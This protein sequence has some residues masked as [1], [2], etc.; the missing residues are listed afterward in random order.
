TGSSSLTDIISLLI[1]ACVE[2]HVAPDLDWRLD[3]LPVD[4]A[5]DAIA[6]L[7]FLPNPDPVRAVHLANPNQRHWRELI[8]WMNLFGYR[9]EIVP[10]E[11][12]LERLVGDVKTHKENPLR[13]LVQ[14]FA[15]RPENE[16]GWYLPQLYEEPRRRK[17][18]FDITRELLKNAR[19]KCPRLSAELLDRYFQSFIDRDFLPE[20]GR[21][22]A[23]DDSPPNEVRPLDVE[24]FRS[25]ISDADVT[26]ARRM[27]FS[28]G[29]SVI[30]ELTSWKYGRSIGVHA[31][32]LEF[33]APHRECDLVVKVKA[34]DI[35]VTTVGQTLA[36]LCSAELG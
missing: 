33:A 34:R 21:S 28:G 27:P 12:W 25:V 7:A 17:V 8:L 10:Y 31:Y 4:F 24:F 19:L 22:T 1:R 20:L 29:H 23:A 5:A 16:N 6:Q 15:Q 26:G 35:E 2:M 32:R 11:D 13:D 9:V 14:F 30:G 18:R 36:T 3:L